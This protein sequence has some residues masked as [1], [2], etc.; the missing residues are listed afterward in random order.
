MSHR[1]SP[2]GQRNGRGVLSAGAGSDRLG[3]QSHLG[4][5][6]TDKNTATSEYSSI[7]FLVKNVCANKG[8]DSGLPWLLM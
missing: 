4:E 8:F 5:F 1:V 3:L 7:T 6:I 2:P